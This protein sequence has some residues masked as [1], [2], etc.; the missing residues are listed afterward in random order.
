MREAYENTLRASEPIRAYANVEEMHKGLPHFFPEYYMRRKDENV[1]IRAIC[2]DNPLSVERHAH[3]KEELRE[4]KLIP[5][6]AYSF[7]PELNIYNNKVLI[8]SWVEKMAIMI[9]SQEIADLHKKLFDLL[10]DKL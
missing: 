10:W 8:A 7:S 6:K 1:S 2:P 4:M 3:D 5:A 9:E